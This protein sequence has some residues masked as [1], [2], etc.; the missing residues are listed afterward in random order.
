MAT[1]TLA[2]PDTQNVI[3]HL[4]QRLALERRESPARV[5]AFIAARPGEGTTTIAR[6]YALTLAETTGQKIVLVDT[7]THNHDTTHRPLGK[8]TF[9]TRISTTNGLLQADAPW[10]TLLGTYHTLII[11]APSLQSTFD[12]IVLA[13]R[14]DAVVIVVEAEATPQP[15]ITHLR[16]T[17]TAAG[18]TIA[19]VVMNKRRYY[20]PER[21]YR[22]L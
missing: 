18:A 6:N 14:A 11:D 7:G 1:D 20:I 17:L 4:V 15:V 5:I 21:I 13:S 8:N 9:T 3:R 2:T 16:D 10:D 19:G 22:R 12:G